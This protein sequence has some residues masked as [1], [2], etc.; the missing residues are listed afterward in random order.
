MSNKRDFFK[1]STAQLR[2]YDINGDLWFAVEDVL[3]ALKLTE[4]D[5]HTLRDE[6]PEDFKTIN[7]GI[8]IISEGGFYY[9]MLFVSTTPDA[10]KFAKWVFG[11]VMPRVLVK[12]SYVLGEE[13]LD[14]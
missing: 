12:G 5:L 14:D 10:R 1:D 3:K 7:D 13:D 4:A 2:S 8:E 9:L 6:E 11:D